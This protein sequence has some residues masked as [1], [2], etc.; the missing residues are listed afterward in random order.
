MPDTWDDVY[1]VLKAFKEA[2]PDGIDQ[3]GLSVNDPF[4]LEMIIAGF[5]GVNTWYQDEDGTYKS[6]VYH[7]KRKEAFEYLHKL[8]AEGLLDPE[9]YVSRADR[10]REYFTSGRSGI[11]YDASQYASCLPYFE[12]TK[13]NF[14]EAEV[15]IINPVPA[16]PDGVRSHKGIDR[17]YF[18]MWCFNKDFEHVDRVLEMMDWLA[19]DEGNMFVRHGIEGIHY[20]MDGDT[21][22]PNV[23]ECEK[24]QFNS[25]GVTSH[26]ISY[27]TSIDFTFNQDMS[28]PYAEEIYTP[29][30]EIGAKYSARNPV[31]GFVY[32]DTTSQYNASIF[33]IQRSYESQFVTG[34]MG[35]DKWDEMIEKL[36]AVDD[37]E[38]ER[39]VNEYMNKF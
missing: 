11:V 33:D 19:S 1:E 2:K 39:Q 34:Q 6:E 17:G 4:W 3:V 28:V 22:V 13:K 15:A 31:L 12:E 16:S 9:C 26:Y 5:T 10:P 32:D 20:T 14:P 36:Q 7:P 23:E 8:Y 27:F 37:G 18:G 35:L 30:N 38:I 29:S 24:D 25:N 21:I